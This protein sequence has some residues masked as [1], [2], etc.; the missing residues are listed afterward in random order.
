MPASAVRAARERAGLS[1]GELA[2]AA[3]MSRAVLGAGV[4]YLDT[5]YTLFA[6]NADDGERLPT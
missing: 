5:G 6:I 4:V 3:G 1:Q 2:R